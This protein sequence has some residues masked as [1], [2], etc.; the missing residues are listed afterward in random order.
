MRKPRSVRRSSGSRSR[1]RVTVER[2]AGADMGVEHVGESRQREV[3]R[4]AR[5]RRPGAART[6]ARRGGRLGRCRAGGPHRRADRAASRSP[7]RA[8]RRR[9][10]RDRRRP[11]STPVARRAPW[12]SWRRGRAR[13]SRRVRARRG[14]A[15]RRVARRASLPGEAGPIAA[16]TRRRIRRRLD[17]RGGRKLLVRDPRLL[18]L[19]ADVRLVDPGGQPG[20][21]DAAATSCRSSGRTSARRAPPRLPSP[22]TSERR[23]RP[24][25]ARRRWFR[26]PWRRAPRHGRP[27]AVSLGGVASTEPSGE[28]SRRPSAESRLPNEVAHHTTA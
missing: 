13:R 23:S 15:S 10:R 3:G 11:G 17:G 28:N 8:R 2:I 22:A 27:P 16:P 1:R 9:H 12:R 5:R 20:V 6:R 26:A 19:A 18:R 21:R 24:S 4:S 25:S 7:P 14:R